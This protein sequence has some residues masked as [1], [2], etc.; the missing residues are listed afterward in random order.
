MF[1]VFLAVLIDL[2][3]NFICLLK[4]PF[5]ASLLQNF[6]TMCLHM[7]S[8]FCSK[9]AQKLLILSSK[10]SF[11]RGLMA[12]SASL[13]ALETQEPTEI[14]VIDHPYF[15]G[16]EF[17]CYFV[18]EEHL[19]L[20]I[21]PKNGDISLANFKAWSEAHQEEWRA[22]LASQG[23]IL[24]RGFPV[25]QAEDFA[26]VVRAVIGR[27]LI[28]YKGEGSR[29]YIVKGVYTSTEAPPKF[30]IPLHHETSC[31]NDPI[32]YICFY[33]DIAPEPGT[34]RTILGRTEEITREMKKRPHLW[35]LFDGK[36]L[37]YTSKHPPEGSF[38]ARVNPTHRT[39]VQAFETT[40]KNEVEQ[41]CAAKGYDFKWNDEWIEVTRRV[42]AIL[43]PDQYFDHPYWYN[44]AHLYHPNPRIRGG[45]ANH[46]LANLLYLLPSTRQYEITFDD[47]SSLPRE[48]VYEIYDILDEKTIGFDWEK[49][50]VVLL[51]NRLTCHGR[52]SYGGPRRILVT[53]IQ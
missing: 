2:L 42:P 27:E 49:G 46:L 4:L 20:V 50:D 45:R 14:G 47:G 41:I 15:L 13:N 33:C 38:F 51:H 10:A 44:Q 26:T 22:L 7:L 12:F 43:G 5:L 31:T 11:A 48:I 39:W 6:S 32:E 18:N 3:R 17:V 29:K 16:E 21:S 36:I 19:P 25:D 8:K 28:D 40:D 35:N 53:M 30:K 34:G 9:S 37:R 52:S 1:K 24:L 23:A